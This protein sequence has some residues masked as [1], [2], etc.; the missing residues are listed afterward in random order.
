[1]LKIK[2]LWIVVELAIFIQKYLF[3]VQ[4]SEPSRMF[5]LRNKKLKIIF[6][7]FLIPPLIWSS[8]TVGRKAQAFGTSLNNYY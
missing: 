5:S 1:M 6:Y 4:S 3:C 8:E 7:L 2:Y